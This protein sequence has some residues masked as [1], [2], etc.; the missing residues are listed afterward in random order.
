MPRN[1]RPA[2]AKSRP[3]LT[4]RAAAT[5]A[6]ADA[7]DPK[8]PRTFRMVANTGDPM[9]IY[10]W[11]NPVVVD[12]DTID[13]SGL[14]IPAL[15]DHCTFDPE[16]IVGLVTA[17]KT[18]GGQF[19]T[20][21][22]FTPTGGEKD[23][24]TRVLA[25]A[26]AG[27]VWQVSIGG[28]PAVTEE[29][30]AGASITVNGRTYAGPV[31]VARG[32]QLREISFVV[33]GGDRRT[34]A[35][36]ARH[37]IKGGAGMTP[38]F[39]EYVASLGFAPADLDETQTANLK[40]QYASEYPEGGGEGEAAEAVTAA[41]EVPAELPADDAEL[42]AME[43]DTEEV[44]ASVDDPETLPTTARAKFTRLQAGLKRIKKARRVLAR[45]ARQNPPTPTPKPGGA[46]DL[47]VAERA[48]VA[49]ITRVCADAKYPKIRAGG[50][51]V[52]LMAHAVAEG[53][54]VDKT[55][56]EALAVKRDARPTGPAVIDRGRERDMTVQALQGAML[57]RAGV[58]LDDKA[59]T[60]PRAAAM[61]IP[62]W[63]R[64]GIND[65][66]RNRYMEAA[67]RYADASAVDLARFALQ[68]S[69]R[70]VPHGR[71]DMIQAAFSSGSALSNIFTTNVN[72]VLLTNYATADDTTESWTTTVD[73]ANFQTQE[74][75]RVE[76]GEGLLPLPRG[77]TADDTK[78]ADNLESYKVSRLARKFTVDEQ[79]M[80]DDNLG[81]ITT[82]PA[83]FG[84]A[85]AQVRPDLV[86]SILLANPTL[87]ATSRALFNSTDGNT[88][89]GAA[90]SRTTIKAAISAMML[91]RE[92]TR[93]LA[94]TPTHLMVPP[95]LMWD[96][97]EL[98]TSA[99]IVLAG[100]AGSVTERGSKNVLSDLN[101]QIVSDSR[102]ENGVTDPITRT[103]YS[104]SSSTWYLASTLAHL[105]E[106]AYI[107]GTGRAPRVRSFVLDRG[108]YGMGWDVS[109][110]IGAKALD[111]KGLQR[112]QA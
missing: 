40:L 14:P 26:D 97:N 110:D 55:K 2:A 85:A 109:L 3:G 5:I 79:D 101:L 41:E 7:T 44:V 50:V 78:F 38:S 108:Q 67:H 93:N 89:S 37:R 21:G 94:L 49:E 8:K 53:W 60:T 27:H 91:I 35:V 47:V 19:V 80:L 96:A 54:T 23:Y 61:K 81:G 22:H 68:A 33:L 65:A 16:F 12:L 107:R 112:R 58:K 29:V 105:I 36:V 43:E 64:A 59:F 30:K 18:E 99:T 86:Y 70:T 82:V 32:V 83:D 77:G 48:R 13:A 45:K 24:A 57:L 100:T 17:A 56:L 1:P 52:D 10:P 34:S 63:L 87:N 102:L 92:G 51:R 90:L 28:D 72:A 15:Y 9:R 46:P 84:L 4:L 20:S 11:D 111:W 88:A 62:D 98:L 106:V 104:G 25:K 69:G 73:V 66:T 6:P 75:V 74:R 103:A 95:T 76:M 71:S 31:I 42:A 39:E